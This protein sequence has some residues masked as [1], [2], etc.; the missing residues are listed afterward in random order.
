MAPPKT[1][2]SELLATGER[3]YLRHPE[4]G[5][6]EEFLSLVRASRRY[7]RPW[8]YPPTTKDG[9]R[10]LVE[11]SESDRYFPCFFFLRQTDALVGVA[12][13]SEIVRGV[14]LS[15]Y[16]GFYGHAGYAGQGLVREGVQILIRHAFRTLKLHRIEA[17]VQP[18]N[19][20]SL[21]LVRALGFRK[22]GLSRRYLKIGGRWRDHER[23]ALLAEDRRT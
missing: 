20:S 6:A 16:L 3:V 21:A 22:E 13:L 11:R 1:K 10:R 19:L 4:R 15:T 14:F 18:T 9:F 12:N 23:W 5:D 17:N 7:H 2:T 8:V